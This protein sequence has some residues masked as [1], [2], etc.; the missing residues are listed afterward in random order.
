MRPG[1]VGGVKD[2]ISAPM[3]IVHLYPV[4]TKDET[5]RD[6][7]LRM[8]TAPTWEMIPDAAWGGRGSEGNSWH[9][10]IIVRYPVSRGHEG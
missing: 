2:T 9:A 4:D 1:A 5:K 7:V 6:D 8:L 10:L 3:M